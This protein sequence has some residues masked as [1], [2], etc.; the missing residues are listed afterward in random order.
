LKNTINPTLASGIEVCYSTDIASNHAS[1]QQRINTMSKKPS[2][3]QA[4]IE[5]ALERLLTRLQ[6]RD[7]EFPDEAWSV[8]SAYN[9]DYECLVDAYDEHCVNK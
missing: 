7:S 5:Q 9:V 4:D 8:A 6:T 3:K 1:E 2:T